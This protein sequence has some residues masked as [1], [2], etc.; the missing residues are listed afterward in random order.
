V[1]SYATAQQVYAAGLVFARLGA[2]IMLLP[3]LGE[4]FIPA[5]IRLSFALALSLMLFPILIGK[6]PALPSGAGDFGLV[7][8]REVLIGLM[9]G[10]VLRLFMTS[11]ATAGEIVSLQTTLSFAQTAN[12]M[13][14][15]PS[16]TLGTFLGLIGIVLIFA[17]DLD[18]LFI[19]AIVKSF[20]LFPFGRDVPVA[21]AGQLA[22][23]T[24]GG[25]FAL[26]VQLAAPVIVFSL[27]FNIAAGLVGRVMPQF[28]VFFAATPLMVLMGLS[29]FALSLGAI[30]M[31]WIDRYRLLLGT[32]VS[33]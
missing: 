27:I 2:I 24:L 25:S 23:Q 15:T 21:D 16:T 8:A 17:T 11:L 10:A 22:V 6:V 28:Q 26:G 31:I 12:P 33:P 29:I 4:T 32:F 13:Q 30:G 1:E 18:H 14:A 7:V 20:D 5:R 9:I 3:G 19:A